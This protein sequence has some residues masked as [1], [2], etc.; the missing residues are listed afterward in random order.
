MLEWIIVG[1]RVAPTDVRLF[2]ML[3]E[4]FSATFGLILDEAIFAIDVTVSTSDQLIGLYVQKNQPG[5][6]T[7]RRLSWR[8]AHLI[9]KV[10]KCDPACGGISR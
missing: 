3:H 6:F 4:I 7:K 1:Q 2:R 8:D 5:Y 9:Q 10:Q